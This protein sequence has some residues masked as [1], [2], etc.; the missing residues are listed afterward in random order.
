MWP[1]N[2][3][4]AFCIF[5]SCFG[6]SHPGTGALKKTSVYPAAVLLT[7]AGEADVFTGTYFQVVTPDPCKAG[8]SGAA[9]PD[10]PHFLRRRCFRGL[11]R[12]LLRDFGNIFFATSRHIEL[13][14]AGR[15]AVV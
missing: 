15:R 14:H 2:W 11:T 8:L 4:F 5:F 10:I 9:W 12:R 6:A 3:V 7:A 13:H 1:D